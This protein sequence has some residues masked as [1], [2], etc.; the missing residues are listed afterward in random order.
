M[1]WD[2]I[3]SFLAV[4]RGGTLSAAAKNEGVNASTLLRRLRSLEESLGVDLFERAPRGYALTH[5]GAAL[6]AHAEEV[7]EA[8]AAFRRVAVG[9]DQQAR[10]E[11]SITLPPSL[12]PMVSESLRDFSSLCPAV[13]LRFIVDPSALELGVEADIALRVSGAPPESAVGRKVAHVAWG[14][15]ASSGALAGI[16]PES[17]P[18]VTYSVGAGPQRATRWRRDRYPEARA[19]LSVN[20]VAAMRDALRAGGQRVGML[21]CYLGDFDDTL[22]TVSAPIEDAGEDLWLLVHADLRRAAR[23]RALLDFLGPRLDARRGEFEG[24][25]AAE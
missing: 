15:Y 4:A 9:H 14:I 13:R 25:G 5:V 16:D 19:I 7:E 10:G 8:V 11:V 23:V 12:V 21:P 1:K 2:E 17:A 20:S 22:A 3:G 24:V 18:W 6:V